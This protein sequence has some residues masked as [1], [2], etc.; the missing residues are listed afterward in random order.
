MDQES[1]SAH[2]LEYTSRQKYICKYM[3]NKSEFFFK[4]KLTLFIFICSCLHY[5]HSNERLQSHIVDCR[6][7]NDCTIRLLSEDKYFSFTNYSKK[8]RVSFVVYTDLECILEKTDSDQEVS[9]R[10]Y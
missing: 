7:I 2:E 1:V 6:R 8:E 4:K 3:I 5:F 9:M 10:T